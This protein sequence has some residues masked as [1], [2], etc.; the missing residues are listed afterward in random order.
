ML[1]YQSYYLSI[2]HIKKNWKIKITKS[3]KRIKHV[4][5]REKIRVYI[6]NINENIEP[7]DVKLIFKGFCRITR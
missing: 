4:T 2:T 1:Y 7:K 5:E 3:I 6:D